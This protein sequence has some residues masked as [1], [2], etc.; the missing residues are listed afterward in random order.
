[1]VVRAE[2]GAALLSLTTLD[3][4]IAWGEVR[5]RREPRGRRHRV[6]VMLD[7]NPAGKGKE[8]DVE[9]AGQREMLNWMCL[10]GALSELHRKP[11]IVEFQ[12]T[13]VHNSSLCLAGE[14]NQI[15]NVGCVAAAQFRG[16]NYGIERVT[17]ERRHTESR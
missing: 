4:W 10:A 11:E 6:Y 15:V 5:T 1:M 16:S 3:R 17:S 13:Y 14:K 2:V 12:Q 7:D 9:D 8:A